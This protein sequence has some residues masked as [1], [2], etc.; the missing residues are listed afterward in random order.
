MDKPKENEIFYGG[1]YHVSLCNTVCL[2]G[3]NVA[4]L[5]KSQPLKKIIAS[6]GRPI[7]RGCFVSQAV[8][9]T[10]FHWENPVAQ[11]VFTTAG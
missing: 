6:R 2:Q 3:D 4:F 7:A 5:T 9:R 11:Y 10:V 8:A 1:Y